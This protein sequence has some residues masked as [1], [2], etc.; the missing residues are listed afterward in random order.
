VMGA[1]IGRASI[2]GGRSEVGISLS[3][4]WSEF[5]IF[6]P[7]G[8]V[9]SSSSPGLTSQSWHRGCRCRED[10]DAEPNDQNTPVRERDGAGK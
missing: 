10:G 4:G 7:L 3:I 2:S 5:G 9:P 6:L 8:C 1:K